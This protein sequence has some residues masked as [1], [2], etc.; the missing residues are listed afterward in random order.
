MAFWAMFEVFGL[1]FYLFL[2]SWY[3]VLVVVA[4]R[5]HFAA[6]LL[7]VLTEALAA[8]RA[9]SSKVFRVQSLILVIVTVTVI[10]RV[11][12]TGT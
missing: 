3:C 2:R 1:L 8:P 11:T 10:V 4:I 5:V 7:E 9:M 6:V 12:V